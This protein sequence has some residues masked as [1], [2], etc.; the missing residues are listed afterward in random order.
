M[1]RGYLQPGKPLHS[2]GSG[3]TP[4]DILEVSADLR[5]AYAEELARLRESHRPRTEIIQEAFALGQSYALE[6]HHL[7]TEIEP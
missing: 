4:D 5:H 3:M 6:L 1:P 2:R 7:L